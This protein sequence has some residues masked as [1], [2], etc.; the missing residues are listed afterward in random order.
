M[1]SDDKVILCLIGGLI[2]SLIVLMGGMHMS[3]RMHND[4]V[5]VCVESG[6]DWDDGDCK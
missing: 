4:T 1:D 3:E 5:R 2:L 6:K